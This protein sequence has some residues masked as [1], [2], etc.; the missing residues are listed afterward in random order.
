MK[1]VPQFAAA[2]MLALAAAGCSASMTTLTRPD[3]GGAQVIY[4]ISE[5]RAFTTALEAYAVLLPKQSVDD[6]VEGSLRG[7]SADERWGLD[8]WTHRVLVIPAVGTD[9]T[10]R[11][12]R[13]YWYKI[14]GS[15]TLIPG[16]EG[17]TQFLRFIR[18]RLDATGAATAVTDVREGSYDTDGHAYLGLKRDARDIKFRVLPTT[19][20]AAVERLAELKA[21]RD[22]G[23]ITEDEYQAKRREILDRM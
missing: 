20:A 10:G 16:E 18:A 23:L 1:G 21:I 9:A 12:V 5:E 14:S 15:G 8:Y 6:V 11:E 13:G 22:N 2:A 3:L 19:G 4:Q 7:Y 17:K